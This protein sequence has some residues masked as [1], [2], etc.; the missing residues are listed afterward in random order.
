MIRCNY[1]MHS[2]FSDGSSEP[3][4]YVESAIRRNFQGI[5]FSEHAPLPFSNKFALRDEMVN[6]Y[7]ETISALKQEYLGHL[8]IYT[9]MEID[10]IPGFSEDFVSMKK[11]WNLDFV[12]GSVHLVVNHEADGLWFI[13]GPATQIYDDG[14]NILFQGD[15]QQAVGAYYRQLQ[16][17]IQKEE[18]DVIGHLDKVKMHNKNRYFKEEDPWYRKL[19]METLEEIR[20]TGC[21]VEVNTRG[22]YKKRSESPFPSYWIIREMNEMNIPILLSSDAHKPEEIDSCFDEVLDSLREV[23]VRE[24]L[25]FS[26]GSWELAGI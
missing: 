13:D 9:G 22:L 14:L 15:I 1:H 21:F 26:G 2:R 5:G 4:E 7:T 6:N 19:L 20:A 18:F 24:L 10:Y 11:N 3:F 16:Q 12:I 8:E 25:I 17:M 23:G